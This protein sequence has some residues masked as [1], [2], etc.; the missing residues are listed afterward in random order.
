M[1]KIK[2]FFKEKAKQTIS[3]C[4]ENK[5]KLIISAV[6]FAV[7]Y[8]I[9]IAN[10]GFG[11]NKRTIL[12]TALCF[13]T[14]L[15]FAIPRPKK[16]YYSLP[17][18][19]LFLLYV[20]GKIF[21]RIELPVHDLTSL[22]EGAELVNILIVILVYA[23]FLLICQNIGIA[24]SAGTVIIGV[25]SVINYYVVNLRGTSIGYADLFAGKTA[26]SVI[27][28]Y[29]LT[30]EPELWYSILYLIFFGV[31]GFW[32]GKRWEQK[33]VYHIVI[34][35]VA[36]AYITFFAVFWGGTDYLEEHQLKGVHWAPSA[37]QPLEGF[38]LSFAINV[39]ESYIQK[40][41]G[42]SEA[43]LER[44][45]EETIASY[46]SPDLKTDVTN[47]NI[48]II[49][50]ETWSD[51]RV[52]GDMELSESYMTTVDSL[53]ENVTKGY[54][55]VPVLGGL[56]ANAEYEV[57]TGNAMALMP[58]NSVPYQLNVNYDMYSLARVMEEQGYESIAMHPSIKGAWNREKVYEHFGFSDFVDIYKFE[59][60]YHYV[61]DY[62]SDKCNYDEI[63]YRYENKEENTPLFLFNVTIQNHGGYGG[64][65]DMP[66]AIES[67]AGVPAS[68]CGD[69]LDAQ[70]YVDLMEISDQ[71]FARLIEYFKNADEPTIICMFG[72]HQ[73]VLSDNFYSHIFKDSTLT[74]EEQEAQKYITPYVI[75]A[76]YDVDFPEY[77]DMSAN[78]LGAAVLECAGVSLP[79]YYKFLLGMQKQ[80]PIITQTTMNELK[81]EEIVNQYEMLQYNQLKRG[82]EESIFGVDP[83]A[84]ED[85]S[86]AVVE[87][88]DVSW[89]ESSN[90][91]CHALGAAPDGETLTNSLD[92]LEYN[93]GNGFRVFE[94]D[95]AIT[96]DNVV[97]CRHDWYSDLGQADAFGWN[98]QEVYEVPDSELFLNTPIYGKYTPMS[99]LDLYEYMDEHEDIYIVFDS[100]Y[101]SDVNG[102][103]SL[104]VNTALDN[105]L[106]HVLD[107]I[108]VQLYYEEMLQ[109]VEG[110]YSFDN[111]LYT[112]Y[113]IGYYDPDKIGEFCKNNDIPVLVMP[114]DT[115]NETIKSDMKNYPV[116]IYLHTVNDADK[117]QELITL[118]ADGI[119]TDMITEN[120]VNK[121]K[122][123]VIISNEMN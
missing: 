90:A 64:G 42:Y 89:H 98:E 1:D 65:A 70:T 53:D 43:E 66:I 96:S 94:V 121:M 56:T 77:G 10:M 4:K 85:E 7:L 2:K 47:P 32:C 26:M 92:A 93:Y 74:A 33:K 61:R 99:L 116:K 86:N 112:L 21:D 51:L 84:R 81:D 60:D 105:D 44:I 22:I 58:R 41:V 59:T 69:L 55:H 3:Y 80:Y 49:M 102:Q 62:I 110:V 30:M 97:V 63:I 24:F 38:L 79:P 45:K 18:V 87:A 39:Q 71:E 101:S 28:S 67:I 9:S 83:G 34:S 5:I 25:L 17:F 20:P 100:K 118:G 113:Y 29:E 40:P 46:Q 8:G 106:E 72:D 82:S 120:E 35:A 76:N 117:A 36:V 50:N 37:N 14:A 57:L 52:L 103:Y 23:V 73:P 104:I 54:L 91:V 11:I 78:Y 88:A 119:Y 108:V 107:R 95:L 13:M 75:W 15:L 27:G 12:M 68:E 6:L 48:I 122:Q 16:W 111:Y 115:M 114:Y 31:W 123:N 19:A 109:E